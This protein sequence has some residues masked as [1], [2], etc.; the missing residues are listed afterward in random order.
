MAS[1][2]EPDSCLRTWFLPPSSIHFW[3]VPLLRAQSGPRG[4]FMAHPDPR[5]LIG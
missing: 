5:V 2:F 3:G 4:W 1:F